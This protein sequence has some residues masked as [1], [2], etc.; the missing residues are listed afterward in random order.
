MS[1]TIS[2][3]EKVRA[4]YSWYTLGDKVG[5]LE[6]Q[7]NGMWNS[8]SESDKSIR[9]HVTKMADP[10]IQST[11]SSTTYGDEALSNFDFEIG[12]GN[13]F[14]NWA[15]V[16]GAGAITEDLVEFNSGVRSI[17]MHTG[18]YITQQFVGDPNTTYKLEYYALGSNTGTGLS[19]PKVSLYQIDGG[20]T[21]FEEAQGVSPTIWTKYT[22]IVNVG[23]GT[24]EIKVEQAD[25]STTSPLNIDD[26]SIKKVTTSVDTDHLLQEPE[27]P[28]RFHMAIV[29]KAI[30]DFY[31]D[32]RNQDPDR[33]Q[34]YEASYEREVLEGKKYARGN[35]IGTGYIKPV[36]F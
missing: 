21:P 4:K 32:P 23:S 9:I 11:I 30:A 31:K 26:I 29:N 25:A 2:D 36:E 5:L 7:T 27:I 34:F 14:T 24:L 10:L 28:R 22:S 19:V 3:V 13:V 8:V 15:S 6:K 12:A 1:Y 16:P 18:A 20:G 33:A 35:H 17:Q